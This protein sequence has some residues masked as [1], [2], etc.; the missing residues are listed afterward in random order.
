MPFA[1]KQLSRVGVSV[2]L[3]AV[4]A[5]ITFSVSRT[6][7]FRDA[8]HWSYDFLVNHWRRV[9]QNRDIVFVDF[10]ETSFREINQFPIPRSAVAQLIRKVNRGAPKVIGLDIF[11]SE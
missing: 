2:V 11:L 6:T 10:D 9:P 3:L 1:A 7:P 4:I 5:L 8:D